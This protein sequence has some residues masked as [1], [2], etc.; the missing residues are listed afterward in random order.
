MPTDQPTDRL[1]QLADQAAALSPEDRS[2]LIDYLM[3]LMFEDIGDADLPDLPDSI[4][5]DLVR[6]SGNAELQAFWGTADGQTGSTSG[7]Y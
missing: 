5:D 1:Q 4:I 6:E 3:R 2:R 7:P